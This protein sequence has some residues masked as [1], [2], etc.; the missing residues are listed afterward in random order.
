MKF[1]AHLRTINR[2]RRLVRKYC[3]RLGLIWQGLTHDLSKYS[4]AEFCPLLSGLPQPERCRAAG[5]GPE[6]VVAA[7]QG[8]QPPSL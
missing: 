3:F 6:P 7:P 2:H 1:L 8:P 4:P 5:H